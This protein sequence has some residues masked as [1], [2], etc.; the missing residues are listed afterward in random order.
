MSQ[1]DQ[2]NAKKPWYKL[3]LQAVNDNIHASPWN[4]RYAGNVKNLIF[5]HVGSLE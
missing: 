1:N 4:P 5:D 2:L 3:I